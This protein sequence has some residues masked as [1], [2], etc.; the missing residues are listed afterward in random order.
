MEFVSRS[1]NRMLSGGGY[2]GYQRV[3]ENL[4]SQGRGRKDS[5]RDEDRM[6]RRR[7]GNCRRRI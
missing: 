7:E 1:K 6:G 3:E 2:D 4:K 5:L